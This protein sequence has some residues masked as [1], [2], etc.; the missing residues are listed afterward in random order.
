VFLRY[1]NGNVVGADKFLEKAPQFEKLVLSV[2]WLNHYV[3]EEHHKVLIRLSFV[4]SASLSDADMKVFD[5]DM[6]AIGRDELTPQIEAAKDRIALLIVGFGAEESDWLVLPD[7]RMLL[8]RY[9]QTPIYGKPNLL[10]W[11]ASALSRKPCAKL[12]DNFVGC[13]GVEITA[14]GSLQP[15]K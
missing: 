13:V 14:D 5:A 10:K 12:P 3:Q 11:S 1:L 7:R 4:G 6:H 9:W 2:P 8:W 15:L